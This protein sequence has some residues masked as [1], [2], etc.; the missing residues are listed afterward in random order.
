MYTAADILQRLTALKAI[1][2]GDLGSS[3]LVPE[4]S[5]RFIRV[6]TEQPTILNV[7][8]R[9]TMMKPERNIDR[10]EIAGDVLDLPANMAVVDTLPTTYTNV[11]K[12]YKLV[13]NIGMEDDTLEENIERENFTDTVLEI[14]GRAVGRNLEKWLLISDTNTSGI[15]ALKDGWLKQAANQIEAAADFPVDDVEGMFDAMLDATPKQY[16]QDLTDWV[17]YTT[18]KIKNDYHNVLKERATPLGD[19]GLTTMVPLLYKGIRVQYNASMP[20][21]KAW[22]TNPD[23]TVYGLM[24]DITMEPDRQPKQFKTDMVLTLR[25]DGNYDDENGATVAAGYTGP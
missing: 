8:R 18:W 1:G 4:Q 6:A 23:N 7:A 24:R 5:D 15:Y 12:S 21:G 17:I 19:T 13:G 2:P 9:Y 22:L 14:Y 11:L 10:M 25:G 16:F 3:L 20:T